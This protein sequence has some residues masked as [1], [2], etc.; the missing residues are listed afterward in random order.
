MGKITALYKGGMSD[1][2]ARPIVAPGVLSTKQ[3]QPSQR[4][5]LAGVLAKALGEDGQAASKALGRHVVAALLDSLTE[6]LARGETVRLRDFGTFR[7]EAR[8]ARTARDFRSG[9]RL[10]VPARRV[11]VFTPGKALASRV[12][13]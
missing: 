9:S 4:D 13:S 7:V 12:R 5:I 1:G 11:A 8:Q 2:K 3:R 10:V 6:A